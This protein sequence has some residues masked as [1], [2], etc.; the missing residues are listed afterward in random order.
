MLQKRFKLHIYFKIGLNR[1]QASQI[2]HIVANDSLPLQHFY[3]FIKGAVLPR[4]NHAEMDSAN[5]LL[6]KLIR[7]QSNAASI[8]ID[9]I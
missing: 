1:S 7:F 2:E 5:S 6:C 8:M 3:F 9:L 4:H